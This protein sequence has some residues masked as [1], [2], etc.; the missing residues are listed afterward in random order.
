MTV[1]CLFP[2]FSEPLVVMEL[3]VKAISEYPSS[4]KQGWLGNPSGDV[5]MFYEGLMAKSN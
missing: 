1:A 5:F 4:I 3:E 2:R